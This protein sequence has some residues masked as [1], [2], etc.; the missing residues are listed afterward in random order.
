MLQWEKHLLFIR[1]YTLVQFDD[2]AADKP[3]QVTE[4]W[5]R[6]LISNV[7]QHVLVVH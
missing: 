7:V 5:D 6:G 4:I 3:D 1:L 2:V